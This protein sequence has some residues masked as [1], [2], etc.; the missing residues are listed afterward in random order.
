M[1]LFRSRKDIEF[2]KRINKELIER[3]IGEKIVYYPISKEYSE[4]NF[5]GESQEKVFHPP[6]EIFA[7]VEWEDQDVTT[8]EYGQDIIY[9]LKVSVLQ[10]HL[11][12]I[13]TKPYEG[14]M[15]GYDDKKFEVTNIK[16]PSQIF[17][18]S[19]EDIG[20]VLQCRSVRESA[21]KVSISGTV[22]YPNRTYPDEPLTASLSTGSYGQSNFPFS[23][24]L[25]DD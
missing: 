14:D 15:I 13:N 16:I 21:F 7:L 23:S 12:E 3:V 19:G 20:Y 10:E 18:K 24:G 25:D 9:N 17:G 22:D 6:V 8:S 1:P 2:V 5:Y 11:K 4:T